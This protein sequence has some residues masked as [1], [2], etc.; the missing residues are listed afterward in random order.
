M[1]AKINILPSISK[2]TTQPKVDSFD[3]GRSN[4]SSKPR[5]VRVRAYY[6]CQ[7]VMDATKALAQRLRRRNSRWRERR[8]APRSTTSNTP[9]VAAAGDPPVSVPATAPAKGK[10]SFTAAPPKPNVETPSPGSDVSPLTQA[11]P[12]KADD[13]DKRDPEKD[14]GTPTTETKDATGYFA[15]KAAGDDEIPTKDA[16]ASR[17]TFSIPTR[18]EKEEGSSPTAEC[19][20]KE[21]DLIV[22]STTPSTAVSPRASQDDVAVAA[23]ADDDNDAAE[24]EV[25][26]SS[27]ISVSGG[28][29]QRSS[30]ASVAFRLPDGALPQ[31]RARRHRNSLPPLSR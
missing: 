11:P 9:A 20:S 28:G 24:E 5:C 7:P 15:L 14:N 16:P 23:T 19:D 4:L 30:I 1:V 18:K 22:S 26:R 29:S 8:G 27:N 25:G 10:T 6:A 13:V 12:R 21:F 17:I 31:G 3:S 2:S